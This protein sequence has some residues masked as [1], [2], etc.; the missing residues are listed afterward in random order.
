MKTKI[1]ILFLI[2][3]LFFSACSYSFLF[4]QE[5]GVENFLEKKLNEAVKPETSLLL[6]NLSNPDLKPIEFRADKPYRIASVIKVFILCA[7]LEK[8]KNSR[9]ER[10]LASTLS[11]KITV[12]A[13]DNGLCANYLKTGKKYTILQIAE[14]MIINSGNNSTNVLI[15]WLGNGDY[16][17]GKEIVNCWS[18]N[19]GFKNTY[20]KRR[21]GELP[22]GYLPMAKENVSTCLDVA[23]LFKQ[24]Y[25]H[26]IVDYQSSELILSLLKKSIKYQ[27]IPAGID[28]KSVVIA[29]KVGEIPGYLHDAAI[30]FDK[31]ND[32]I[33]V[34]LTKSPDNKSS[35]M[36]KLSKIIWQY[37]KSKKF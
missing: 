34:I 1:K 3:V 9:G 6:W 29:N 23:N 22:S 33:L 19:N 7:V 35:Y 5:A 20:I 17:E 31:G 10:P 37:Y 26:K 15:R 12:I 25:E 21:M 8:V 11:A 16:N 32:Y 4:A 36:A 28:D 2:F 30:V 24:I 18:I 13:Q 14:D 27:E